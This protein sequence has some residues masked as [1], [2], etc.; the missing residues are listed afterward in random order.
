MP[1]A[2]VDRL[3]AELRNAASL[4]SVW[5]GVDDN[6]RAAVVKVLRDAAYRVETLDDEVDVLMEQVNH[7]RDRAS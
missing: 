6:E 7:T 2:D 3:A 1:R 4:V 5:K